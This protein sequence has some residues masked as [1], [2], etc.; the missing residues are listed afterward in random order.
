LVMQAPGKLTKPTTGK[1][2]GRPKTRM[3]G[4]VRKAE[5]AELSEIIA[6]IAH[7]VP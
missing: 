7:D 1:I 2:R 6:R 4:R 3:H 5:E